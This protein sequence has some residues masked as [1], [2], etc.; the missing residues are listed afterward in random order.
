[1]E[2]CYQ[3]LSIIC[4][5]AHGHSFYFLCLLMLELKDKHFFKALRRY[6]FLKNMFLFYQKSHLRPH[7]I[8]AA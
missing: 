5:N 2:E 3:L 1:M 6:S 4:V 7:S 8:K